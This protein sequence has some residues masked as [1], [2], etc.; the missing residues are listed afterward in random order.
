MVRTRYP[1]QAESSHSKP[2]RLYIPQL[3]RT[4]NFELTFQ[5]I[6]TCHCKLGRNPNLRLMNFTLLRLVKFW[7]WV[8]CIAISVCN[9]FQE[10]E[11]LAKSYRVSNIGYIMEI[12]TSLTE[13]F[14]VQWQILT[15]QCTVV[16][17]VQSYSD[18]EEELSDREIRSP[19]SESDP[20]EESK[21]FSSTW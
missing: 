14:Y 5:S 11:M 17:G 18:M 19:L 4:S 13:V 16:G 9:L 3:E 1:F 15:R 20:L 2:P 7:N 21:I 6:P 8:M 12:A 10:V